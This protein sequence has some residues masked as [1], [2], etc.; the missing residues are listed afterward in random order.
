VKIRPKNWVKRKN[1]VKE[2]K[3]FEEKSCEI[4]KN[5]LKIFIFTFFRL[6]FFFKI[7][8][9]LFFEKCSKNWI[10]EKSYEILEKTATMYLFFLMAYTKKLG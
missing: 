9:F 4:L 2:K 3:Y 5:M 7:L 6:D 10:R 1:W 8:F